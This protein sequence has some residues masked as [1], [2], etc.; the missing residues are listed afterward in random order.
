MAVQAI[1]FGTSIEKDS[2]K[3]EV[4]SN[5]AELLSGG[6]ALIEISGST[7]LATVRVSAG[8]RDVTSAF[9]PTADGRKL[10]GLVTGL[11]EGTTVLTA[12]QLRGKGATMTL[13]ITR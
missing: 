8:E 10:R 3:I 12:T 5:R 6:D 9:L 1:V 2:L 13:T 7:D 4:L 11:P